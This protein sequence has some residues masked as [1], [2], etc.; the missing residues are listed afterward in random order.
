MASFDVS[1]LFTNIPLNETIDL[2]TDLIF[3]ESD[4][5]D[6]SDCT[7]KRAEFK[8]LICLA[9]KKNHFIFNGNL[10]DRM[11][12]VAM[13]SP[14]GPAFANKFMSCLEKNSLGSCPDEF[15][16]VLYR[17]YL[18]DAFCLFH[19]KEHAEKFL[20][21]IN[22]QHPNIKFTVEFENDNSIPFLD[23]LVTR[24]DTGFSTSLYRKKTYTGLYSNF[25]SLAPDKYK[26]NLISV[27]ILR[28]FQIC[29]SYV[30]FHQEITRIKDIL[31]K[32]HFPKTLIDRII[33]SFLD[34][35]YE[36]KF[37]EKVPEIEKDIVIFCMPYFGT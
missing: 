14:L 9:V 35:K 27:L 25:D 24:D 13:G 30:S 8:K 3:D 12:G 5:F 37:K 7:F 17:W 34:K 15:W 4:S 20:D 26:A 36:A 31:C 10:Y 33:K 23:V 22:S 29:S 11:D 16:P 21:F 2:C 18:D 6:F 28:A 1:S 19:K 32:N